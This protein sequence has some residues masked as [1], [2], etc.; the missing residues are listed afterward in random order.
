MKRGK[1]AAHLAGWSLG[2]AVLL[3]SLLWLAWWAFTGPVQKQIT[4]AM[5]PVFIPAFVAA[6]LISGNAHSV[7]SVVWYV[8]QVVQLF[9]MIYL[10]AWGVIVVRRRLRRNEPN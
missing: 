6:A 3:V 8:C 9:L 7:G 5:L 1:T 10:V 4:D 2:A